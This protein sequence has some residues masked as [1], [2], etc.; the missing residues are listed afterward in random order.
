MV[1]I[2]GKGL[3]LETTD[4]DRVA[5]PTG[6]KFVS[7]ASPPLSADSDNAKLEP[8]IEVE[9]P[10]GQVGSP[11]VVETDQEV[12]TKDIPLGNEPNEEVAT[13]GAQDVLIDVSSKESDA[14][15]SPAIV[16]PLALP[17]TDLLAQP[18][19]QM[20]LNSSLLSQPTLQVPV[21]MC[22]RPHP[23]TNRCRRHSLL[24]CPLLSPR[25]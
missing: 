20:I 12:I 9:A 18:L 21:S 23:L 8:L 16:A 13:C 25:T 15:A 14:V 3:E 17:E 6:E 5:S 24:P 2:E 10:L 4:N 22:R 11:D 1:D 7:N 19:C